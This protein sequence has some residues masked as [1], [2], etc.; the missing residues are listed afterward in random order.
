[1]TVPLLIQEFSN[2]LS[3]DLMLQRRFL[4]IRKG[5]LVLLCLLFIAMGNASAGPPTRMLVC[6]TSKGAKSEAE[7]SLAKGRAPGI[8]NVAFIG[9]QP[10]KAEIDR[11]LR[12]CIKVASKI[13]SSHD[14]LGTAWFRKRASDDPSDDEIINNYGPLRYLSY[15]AKSKS[16]EARDMDFG[17]R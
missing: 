2:S 13:D 14:I 7:F 17:K 3:A 15:E 4:R 1:M 6:A 8:V 11:I 16:I 12:D 9:R 5:T 10:N